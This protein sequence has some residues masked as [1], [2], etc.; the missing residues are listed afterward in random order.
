MCCI[1]S[2]LRGNTVNQERKSSQFTS[3]RH[4]STEMSASWYCHQGTQDRLKFIICAP[5]IN[6]SK[7][8]T[9]GKKKLDIGQNRNSYSLHR[10]VTVKFEQGKKKTC[11]FSLLEALQAPVK[12]QASN[13][14]AIAGKTANKILEHTGQTNAGLNR[15]VP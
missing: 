12:S 2:I 11:R 9:W 8:N 15:H 7:H 13:P 4:V 3:T 1:R 14:D 5:L 10:R 6:F